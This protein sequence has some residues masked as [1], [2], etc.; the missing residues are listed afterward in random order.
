MG[1]KQSHIGPTDHDLDRLDPKLPLRD[2][3]HDL[4]VTDPTLETCAAIDH[5]DYTAPTWQ[6]ELDHTDHTAV[7]YTHLT[8][9]TICSV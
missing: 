2:V 4:Y 1:A 8:L 9:P 6:H 3:V 7:S 5:A